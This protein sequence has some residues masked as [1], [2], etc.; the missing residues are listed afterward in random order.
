M[1]KEVYNEFL[2]FNLRYSSEN[3]KKKANMIANKNYNMT[4][5]LKENDFVAHR[6][7]IINGLRMLVNNLNYIESV[8]T[9][10]SGREKLIK[11]EKE[12]VN[13]FKEYFRSEIE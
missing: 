9:T 1:K 13:I 5:K 8:K 4:K 11:M 3:C 6:D 12:I 10:I 2:Q 7:N